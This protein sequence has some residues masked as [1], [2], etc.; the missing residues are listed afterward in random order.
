MRSCAESPTCGDIGLVPSGGSRTDRT[1]QSSGEELAG[2]R[3]REAN[4]G[5]NPGD[6]AERANSGIDLGD[7]AERA[8][9]G[10]NPGDSIVKMTSSDSSSSVRVVASSGSGEA[11][12]CD[13]EVGSSGA[14]SGP[15]SP[16]N[17][18]VLRDL[19]FMKADHDLD[20]VVTEGSLAVIRERYNIPIEYGLHVP[21]PGQHPY[22]SDAPGMC[23][24]VDALE[25]DLWFPLHPL[26]EGCL[27]WWRISPSQVAPNSWCYL[28]VFPG[29]C[30]G[31]GIIPT[32]DL[33]MS[34]FHLCKSRGDYYLTAR[35]GFRVSG[36]PYNNKG[37][38]S[39]YLFVSDPVWGFRLDWSAHPID[40]AS[41]Y[42]SE[43]ESV[44][45]GRLKGILSSSHVI[46]EMT[47]LWLVE[48]AGEPIGELSNA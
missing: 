37:W 27:R 29:E 38:K 14:S 24:S 25:A 47:E 28:I 36:A 5:T 45:V 6:L 13:P 46:K 10:T 22:S 18:R 7:L 21:Q 26:I 19:E 30:R 2:L 35:V 40:N 16:V 42:L 1:E 34:C 9:S 11:S 39:R 33:F 23:I 31:A 43:E 17:A 44:L 41:P 12:R 32:R 20:T 3:I 8:N 15:S 4:S 48:A